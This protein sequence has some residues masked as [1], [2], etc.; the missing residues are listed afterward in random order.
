MPKDLRLDDT[1][2]KIVTLL[3]QDGRMSNAALAEA[4]GIAQ[5][6]CL[7]RLRALRDSGV[8]RGFHAEVDLAALGYALQALVSVRLA[9]HGRDQ[10]GRFRALATELPGVLAVYHV[11]GQTDYLL[12]VA[13]PDADA[14]R[15]FVLDHLVTRSSIAHAET[16]LIFEHIRG[17]GI[18]A[19]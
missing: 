9:G 12:H 19:G 10:I 14:L 7:T 5:S 16:S 13:V 15:D 3:A 18:T 4:C 6:T 11:T 2:R 17:V 8:I 1:D